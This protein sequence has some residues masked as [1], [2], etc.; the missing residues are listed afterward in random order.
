MKIALTGHYGSGN[1]G[2]EAQREVI[3]S[4]L[5]NSGFDVEVFGVTT[6]T[7]PRV[8]QLKTDIQIAELAK[9]DAIVWGGGLACLN[10]PSPVWFSDAYR[11]LT[12]PQHFFC[13]GAE[14][15]SDAAKSVYSPSI[16]KA[17][18]ISFRDQPSAD[19]FPGVESS[20]AADLAYLVSSP[21]RAENRKCF[22]ICPGMGEWID[23]IPVLV[24]WALEEGIAESAR[25]VILMDYNDEYTDWHSIKQIINDGLTAVVAKP[26]STAD[27]M[28]LFAESS[29]TISGRRHGAILAAMAGSP[30]LA[31]GDHPRMRAVSEELKANVHAG[32]NAS[33]DDLK[34]AVRQAARLS[35]RGRKALQSRV[36]LALDNLTKSLRKGQ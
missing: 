29:V 36:S 35:A 1:I 27:A 23:W 3:E 8:R 13:I 28:T 17:V 11:T 21:H 26:W 31:V 6:P 19:Q 15:L 9:F 25:L 22:T 18:S 32:A 12:V 20:V 7:D 24:Q 5:R 4:H 30:V 10:Q 14:T 34:Q 33:L 16:E 2:D